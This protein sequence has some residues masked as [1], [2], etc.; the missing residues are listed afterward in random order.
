M[1]LCVCY[2]QCLLLLQ[3]FEVKLMPVKIGVSECSSAVELLKSDSVTPSPKYSEELEDI[4]DRYSHFPVLCR[5][6][7]ELLCSMSK[8]NHSDHPGRRSGNGFSVFL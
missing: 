2:C 7:C 8:L 4:K 3:S 5:Q 6:S 1:C